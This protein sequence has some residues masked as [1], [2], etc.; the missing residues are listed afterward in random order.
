MTNFTNELSHVITNTYYWYTIVVNILT[1]TSALR[2]QSLI[3]FV[4]VR[5]NCPV[6]LFLHI[7][8]EQLRKIF[9]MVSNKCINGQQSIETPELPQIRQSPVIITGTNFWMWNSYVIFN[10]SAMYCVYII[11]VYAMVNTCT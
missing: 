1:I 11:Q 7:L 10:C 6:L 4:V 8:C 3:S 5:S 2:L 9:L